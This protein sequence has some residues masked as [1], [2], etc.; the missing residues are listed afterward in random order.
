MHHRG[1]V[2]NR[3]DVGGPL[4]EG[5]SFT[6]GPYLAECPSQMV[7]RDDV[8]EACPPSE[9][10]LYEQPAF[11]LLLCFVPMALY[12]LY[13][14][15]S[16]TWRP[17]NRAGVECVV[18]SGGSLL[19]S[20]TATV[21]MAWAERLA[22]HLDIRKGEVKVDHAGT[23]ALQPGDDVRINGSVHKVHQHH[24]RCRKLTLSEFDGLVGTVMEKPV[25]GDLT[26][27]VSVHGKAGIWELPIDSLTLLPLFV[28]TPQETP[29]VCFCVTNEWASSAEFFSAVFHVLAMRNGVDIL[30]ELAK[31]T[32]DV[33]RGLNAG[34]V[35]ILCGDDMVSHAAFEEVKQLFSLKAEQ[36]V[37]ADK[38]GGAVD[39]V[40]HVT[41][42]LN[43]LEHFLNTH[44]KDDEH[45][46]TQEFVREAIENTN[47]T[48]DALSS[49]NMQHVAT[50]TSMLVRIVTMHMQQC[51]VFMSWEWSWP[52]LLL[53]LRRWI[54][55]VVLFDLPTIT[56]SD[57]L[58]GGGTA[59]VYTT[60]GFLPAFILFLLCCS[61]CTSSHKRKQWMKN[62]D[63]AAAATAAHMANFG[64]AVYTL[65]S[66]V[67]VSGAL[68]FTANVQK[69][70][71]NSPL[72]LVPWIVAVPLVV[73]VPLAALQQLQQAKKA[74]ILHSRAFEARFGWLCSRCDTSAD[75]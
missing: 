42:A 71:D 57:C 49:S 30:P 68:I 27:P 20:D 66:P 74:G 60:G 59:A 53:D 11:F 64:W 18:Y 29:A 37:Y 55:S 72:W 58:V 28:D 70:I 19:S 36:I 56:N 46:R 25:D 12:A 7:V 15:A 52:A 8:C 75:H 45:L 26:V 67:T 63:E 10:E 62:G 22:A 39:D 41:Q 43:D 1:V 40:E 6:I 9:G 24:H 44:R 13:R 35:F 17:S 73:F 38:A 61:C 16:S 47:A 33:L 69:R 34:V 23:E 51:F 21:S 32:P 48:K 50:H 5:Q 14:V 4:K 54:G 2:V 3:R 65:G 31:T